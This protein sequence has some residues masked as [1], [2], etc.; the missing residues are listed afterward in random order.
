[1]M[2]KHESDLP[3]IL[4]VVLLAVSVLNL[5]W[6]TG[7]TYEVAGISNAASGS[8]SSLLSSSSAVEKPNLPMVGA[9]IITYSSCKDCFNMKALTTTIESAGVNMTIRT[10]DYNTAEGKSLAEANGVGR[11]P[12][13]VLSG[14]I[15]QYGSIFNA[16]EAFNILS[17]SSD[18]YSL[19]P[20]QPPYLD[21]STGKVEGLVQLVKITDSSCTECYNASMDNIILNNFGVVL[22]NETTYDV[23]SAAGKSAVSKYNITLVPTM[24]ISPNVVEYKALS[25]VWEQVG[26]VENDGWFVF[27]NV[28]LIGTYKDISANKVIIVNSQGGA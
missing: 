23:N 14:D 19:G 9:T 8:S 4:A 12:S 10:V 5:V 28:S 15:T 11:L 13:L 18:G 27:R 20:L 1:M 2:L 25:R 16:L 3:L 24:L 7:L 17:K 26:T 21:L 6:V 22:A